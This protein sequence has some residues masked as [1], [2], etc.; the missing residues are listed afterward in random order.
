MTV[1]QLDKNMSNLRTWLSRI[2]AELARPV[3]Y[4]VCHGEEIQ[5]KLAEQQVSED[6]TSQHCQ[7]IG[8][9]A[10][11]SSLGLVT[12][13]SIPSYKFSD[14]LVEIG[15]PHVPVTLSTAEKHEG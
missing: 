14:A 8:G 6:V 5:R 15:P 2:E 3:V 1:Q 9:E 4:T 12:S 7:A 10:A 13:P 11:S